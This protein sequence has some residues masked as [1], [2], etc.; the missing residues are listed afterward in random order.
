MATALEDRV[1]TQ[2]SSEGAY[3][4]PGQLLKTKKM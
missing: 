2:G 1:N 4:W 3:G